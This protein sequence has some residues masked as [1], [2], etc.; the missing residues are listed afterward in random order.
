VALASQKSGRKASEGWIGL[1]KSTDG[2]TVVMV[3]VNAETDFVSRGEAFSEAAT[4]LSQQALVIAEAEPSAASLESVQQDPSVATTITD[5]IAQV[6]ENCRLSRFAAL[7][8]TVPAHLRQGGEDS[9]GTNQWIASYL[10]NVNE[11]SKQLAGMGVMVA[12]S[13]PQASTPLSEELNQLSS[14][15]AMHIA[16]GAPTYVQLSNIPAEHEERER[17]LLKGADDLAGKPPNVQANIVEGR[18]KKHWKAVTLYEQPWLMDTDV[19]V[20]NVRSFN[21]FAATTD[22]GLC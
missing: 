21:S 3:E 10:H 11:K 1:Q 9:T 22:V 17:Q 20:G 4:L 5:L 14:H 12:L 2:K 16:A 13:S 8:T 6:R 19:T 7:S 18:L 15:L